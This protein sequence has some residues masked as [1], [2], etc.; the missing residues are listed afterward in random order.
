MRLNASMPS[1]E[2]RS[3][4]VSRGQRKACNWLPEITLADKTH[5]AACTI[6]AEHRRKEEKN[7]KKSQR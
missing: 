5:T 4:L 2:G 3:V 7:N 6:S 1:P